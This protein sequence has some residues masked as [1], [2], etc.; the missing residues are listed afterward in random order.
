MTLRRTSSAFL[1]FILAAKSF[2][3]CG[4][5][6]LTCAADNTCTLCYSN[7]MLSG[8]KCTQLN[9]DQ[10]FCDSSTDLTKCTDSCTLGFAKVDN[11]CKRC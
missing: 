6:C 3:E 4:D 11:A 8:G 1:L 2:Q 10:V 7:Y 5:N 9:K